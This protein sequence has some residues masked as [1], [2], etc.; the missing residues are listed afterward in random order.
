MVRLYEAIDAITIGILK[1]I[2]EGEEVKLRR[3][4]VFKTKY[5]KATRYSDIQNPGKIIEIPG[6]TTPYFKPSEDL[7]EAARIAGE[8]GLNAKYEEK[9]R[10]SKA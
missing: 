4:G 3:L 9:L 2:E 5:N 10:E 7:K 8:N 6:R 1:A